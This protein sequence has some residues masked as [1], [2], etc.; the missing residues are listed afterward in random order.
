MRRLHAERAGIAAGAV[1]MVV[2]SATW[3][4][5]D[6]CP[7]ACVRPLAI[8]TARM[9]GNIHLDL[10]DTISV[11]SPCAADWSAMS[12]DD[13]RRFCARCGL[14]VHDLSAMSRT[15]AEEFIRR[16]RDAS[17]CVRFF[18]RADGTILTRDCPVGVAAAKARVR[19]AVLRIAASL[20]LVATGSIAA[21]RLDPASYDAG[22]H[23]GFMQPFLKLRELFRPVAPP[24]IGRAVMGDICL[25]KVAPAPPTSPQPAGAAQSP[26]AG[27]DPERHSTTG[28]PQ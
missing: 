18:R 6:P 21:A 24:P 9:S 13:R 16:A 15:Q 1:D 20:G 7:S 2:S 25:G 22:R 10:L 11:A 23:V 26:S 4:R 28:G 8:G 27:A 12:G 14:H 3:R 17:T 19:R 5:W